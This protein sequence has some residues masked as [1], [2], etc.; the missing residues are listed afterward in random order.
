MKECAAEK[1]KGRDGERMM[2]EGKTPGEKDRNFA[3]F[4]IHCTLTSQAGCPVFAP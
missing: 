4:Y 1:A 3:S 2:E